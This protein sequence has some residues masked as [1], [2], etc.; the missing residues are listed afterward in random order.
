MWESNVFAGIST[1]YSSFNFCKIYVFLNVLTM[2]PLWTI[3]DKKVERAT[4]TGKFIILYDNWRFRR[5]FGV[6]L[7]LR[8]RSIKL[9][10]H[11]ALSYWTIKSI[12]IELKRWKRTLC[13]FTKCSM[14][15]PYDVMCLSNKSGRY[16]IVQFSYHF[17]TVLV[18]LPRK[19]RATM[20]PNTF[21]FISC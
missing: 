17:A 16:Y 4:Q 15:I 11:E 12:S 21:P 1:N 2:V 13:I 9:L 19:W 14:L 20:R 10:K 18:L 3:I 8:M 7:L 5:W 6:D